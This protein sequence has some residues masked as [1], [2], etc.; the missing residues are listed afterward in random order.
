MALSFLKV[1]MRVAG[2]ILGGEGDG[3]EVMRGRGLEV[4][5]MNM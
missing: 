1:C 3:E 2:V 5:L 4:E